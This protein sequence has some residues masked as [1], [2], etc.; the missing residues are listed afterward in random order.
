M[1]DSR[2]WVA[3]GSVVG[4]ALAVMAAPESVAGALVGASATGVRSQPTMKHSSTVEKP[5][6][7]NRRTRDLPEFE[8]PARSLAYPH[9]ACRPHGP[10]RDR[11]PVRGLRVHAERPAGDGEL[12]GVREGDRRQPRRRPRAHALG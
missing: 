3:A 11:R 10:S 4:C 1:T 9:A 6:Q 5:E 12:P 8:T 2:G 7:T